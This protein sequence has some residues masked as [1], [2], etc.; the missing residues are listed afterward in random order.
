MILQPLWCHKRNHW[1]I[2]LWCHKRNHWRISNYLS[3]ITFDEYRKYQLSE[4][5]HTDKIFYLFIYYFFLARRPPVGQGLIIETSRSHSFRHAIFSRSP[6]DKWSA[7]RKD[8]YLTTHH[9]PKRHPCSCGIQTQNSSK[10]ARADPHLLLRGNW[11]RPN[12][13]IT[14]IRYQ[15][16]FANAIRKP[17][18]TQNWRLFQL[19][20][21][22]GMYR[23]YLATVQTGRR[24]KP[25]KKKRSTDQRLRKMTNTIFYW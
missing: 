19:W 23:Q 15:I 25:G 1:R 13:F 14:N 9:N 12:C 17:V 21:I 11:D 16:W 24:S 2:S 5:S 8:L 3:K 18:T 20:Y 7:R 6:L 4:I 22:R 10:R